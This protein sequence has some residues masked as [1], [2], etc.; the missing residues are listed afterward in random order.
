[1]TLFHKSRM[2]LV[3][4]R[5]TP[6]CTDRSTTDIDGRAGTGHRVTV[7]PRRHILHS[8]SLFP[9]SM[10]KRE[11]EFAQHLCQYGGPAATSNRA[12]GPF[13]LDGARRRRG[14]G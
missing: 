2:H 7:V 12:P 1:M 3:A 5:R 10:C 13:V 9:V 8:I 4:I 6:A 14:T 11:G